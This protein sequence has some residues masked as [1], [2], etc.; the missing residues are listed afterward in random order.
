MINKNRECKICFKK[1]KKGFKCS[2]CIAKARYEKMTKFVYSI[3]GYSCWNCG[4]TKGERCTS[5]L[6]FHHIIPEDKIFGLSKREYSN[7]NWKLVWVEMQKCCVLC[8]NCHREVEFF[9]TEEEIELVE[10]KYNKKWEEIHNKIKSGEINAIPDSPGYRTP[11]INHCECGKIIY[12][13]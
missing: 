12:R 3:V 13:D 8:A 7:Y 5:V 11:K 6:E 2:H 4:Y 1:L 10:Q 9:A